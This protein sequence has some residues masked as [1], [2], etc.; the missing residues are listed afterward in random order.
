MKK[1]ISILI[2]FVMALSLT[3]CGGSGSGEGTANKP[4]SNKSALSTYIN[5]ATI[6][7]QDNISFAFGETDS[8][9]LIVNLNAP[10]LLNGIQ[11][12]ADSTLFNSNLKLRIFGKSYMNSD[13]SSYFTFKGY[14]EIQL[15]VYDASEIKSNNAQIIIDDGSFLLLN[16]DNNYEVWATDGTNGILIKADGL[17]GTQIKDEEA[18]KTFYNTVKEHFSFAKVSKKSEN[19]NGFAYTTFNPKKATVFAKSGNASDVENW[20]FAND[21]LYKRLTDN[22]LNL[23]TA[24]NMSGSNNY[25]L[26]HY[27][28]DAK[29]AQKNGLIVKLITMSEIDMTFDAPETENAFTVGNYQI[30]PDGKRTD[31]YAGGFIIKT[32]TGKEYHCN[33]SSQE[34]MERVAYDDAAKYIKT[35]LGA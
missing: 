2:A 7:S 23:S 31:N 26:A 20:T 10:E 21:L 1:I 5:E 30:V 34:I 33:I 6:T 16:K 24:F 9:V 35:I 27:D 12:S 15:K 19:N 8:E 3:A 11:S 25:V 18:F 4:S 22:G 32:S 13:Y 28:F 17:N 29:D 14:G